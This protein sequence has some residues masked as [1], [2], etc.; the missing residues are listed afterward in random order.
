[1]KVS[2]ISTL[3]TI[4]QQSFMKLGT[5]TIDLSLTI[6]PVKQTEKYKFYFSWP[7]VNSEMYV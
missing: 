1:M 4:S 5:Y 6:I 7:Q 2:I 3:S